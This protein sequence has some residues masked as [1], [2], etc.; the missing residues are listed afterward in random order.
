MLEMFL[1]IHHQ[2]GDTNIDVF[3]GQAE[4]FWVKHVRKQTCCTI[5][6]LLTSKPN[7]LIQLDV[8]DF[9]NSDFFCIMSSLEFW[10]ILVLCKRD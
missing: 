4:K 1:D 10:D 9:Q 7:T 2:V 5:E 6:A 3:V 8:K